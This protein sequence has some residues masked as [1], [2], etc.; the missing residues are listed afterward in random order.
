MHWRGT[1]HECSAAPAY[2]PTVA[3][4]TSVRRT[5]SISQGTNAATLPKRFPFLAA[6]GTCAVGVEQGVKQVPPFCEL[7]AC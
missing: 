7:L 2:D 3:I 4:L 6:L 5:A 1:I